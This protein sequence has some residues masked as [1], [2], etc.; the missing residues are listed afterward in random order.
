[1]KG[2]ILILLFSFLITSAFSQND[3]Y[4]HLKTD[5]VE[6]TGKQY[7]FN[8][9]GDTSQADFILSDT[10]WL[11]VI[12]DIKITDSLSNYYAPFGLEGDRLYL[13]KLN[14]RYKI[15]TNIIP[16]VLLTTSHINDNYFK[17]PEKF[18]YLFVTHNI[19]LAKR[20][21]KAEQFYK[22]LP[23]SYTG[24]EIIL[25][26]GLKSERVKEIQLALIEKGYNI[27]ETGAN[28]VMNETTKNALLQFQKDN[29]LPLGN[30]SLETQ[31]ALGING[32]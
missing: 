6:Y 11:F 3:W 23:G 4:Q 14:P 9:F 30:I 24:K 2:L 29:G 27:G 19:Q 12:E 31:R 20:H 10:A 16:D 22:I 32:H 17:R 7:V 26:G 25:C 5:F 13:Q 15:D 18:K 1:M 21:F 8:P 28:N